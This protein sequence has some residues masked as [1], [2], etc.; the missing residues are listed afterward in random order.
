MREPIQRLTLLVPGQP[1]SLEGWRESLGGTGFS[2]DDSKLQGPDE[3]LA[4]GAEWIPNDG[5][6]GAA[7]SFGT[8]P[9]ETVAAI[10]A[11][12][13]ALLVTSTKDLREGRLELLATLEA[14]QSA[15][16]LA[17]RIEE[18]KAGWA[19]ERW[20]EVLSSEDPYAWQNAAVA[21]LWGETEL[22]T[23]GMHAFSLPDVFIGL[24]ED[25]AELLHLTTVLNTYQID[26]DPLLFSGH[27][28]APDAETPR[29]VLER[30]PDTNYPEHHACHNP[31]GVWRLGPPGGEARR[32][33]KVI[34]V[35]VP[36]LRVTL[37]SLARQEGRAPL[38][39]EEVETH[40]DDAP[41]VAMKPRQ[42]QE[43]ERSRGYADLNPEFVWEQWQ[44]V[45]ESE[46]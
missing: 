29:R 5:E 33:P 11:A 19:I 1:A 22:Q 31:Y 34:P 44:L 24:E 23:C 40:R 35:F 3:A 7:F 45:R 37:T 15:G 20:I 4:F 6:F 38:A 30:W 17:M 32:G 10:D 14:L 8:V 43:L 9:P 28:F 41:C 18:S 39:R 26:E 25:R 36:A 2:L 16:A 12:P 27:T 13:G 42:A 46:R 21:Y